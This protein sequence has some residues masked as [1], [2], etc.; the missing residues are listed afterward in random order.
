[1]REPCLPPQHPGSLPPDAEAAR[2]ALESLGKAA[3]ETWLAAYS[4]YNPLLDALASAHNVGIALGILIGLADLQA[5]FLIP[6]SEETRHRGQ[7]G[8]E[9]VLGTRTIPAAALTRSLE[10]AVDAGQVEADNP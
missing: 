2:T 8:I 7:V 6:G 5:G 10:T 1:M 3:D 9:V 4:D